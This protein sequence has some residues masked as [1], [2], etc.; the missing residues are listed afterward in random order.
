MPLKKGVVFIVSI[1][2]RHEEPEEG[3]AFDRSDAWVSGSQGGHNG[4]VGYAQC[5][6]RRQSDQGAGEDAGG[7]REPW[8]STELAFTGNIY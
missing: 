8:G 1:T 2:I 4:E 7:N 3:C 6:K 5:V